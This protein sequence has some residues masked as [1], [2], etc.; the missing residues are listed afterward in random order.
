MQC[1][2]EQGWTRGSARSTICN[3]M[4]CHLCYCSR[5]PNG[6]SAVEFR[7]LEKE[8][9]RQLWKEQDRDNWS[10]SPKKR[11]AS[12]TSSCSLCSL[13]PLPPSYQNRNH[14]LSRTCLRGLPWELMANMENVGGDQKLE[15]ILFPVIDGRKAVLEK[16]W[17]C[18]FKIW[19]EMITL[20]VFSC[21]VIS[22]LNTQQRLMC[23][24][25]NR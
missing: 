20:I 13:L 14:S 16:F 18:N 22:Q 4:G 15:V 5:N 11:L 17:N 23:V 9:S 7:S 10:Q 21:K 3:Y 2:F 8:L 19:S 6:N 12:Q 25:E 24:A 1:S